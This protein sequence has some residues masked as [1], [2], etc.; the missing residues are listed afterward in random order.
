MVVDCESGGGRQYFFEAAVI[1]AFGLAG[2]FPADPRLAAGWTE[3]SL[4]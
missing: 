2:E 4:M 3:F 1:A